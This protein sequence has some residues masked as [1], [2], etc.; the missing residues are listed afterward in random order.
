MGTANGV[1]CRRNIRQSQ[2]QSDLRNPPIQIAH[3]TEQWVALSRNQLNR[4]S[5]V[6]SQMHARLAT[7]RSPLMYSLANGKRST[8]ALL[9]RTTSFNSAVAILKLISDKISVTSY[10]LN[11]YEIFLQRK[12]SVFFAAIKI[13]R[14]LYYQNYA[15]VGVTHTAATALAS[16]TRP[17]LSSPG[18]NSRSG[19]GTFRIV[20]CVT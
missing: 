17:Q 16:S 9:G 15:M 14:F 13:S 4:M 5:C 2:T 12:R 10:H 3:C 20:S 1:E 6:A 7:F 18:F 8:S 19:G 11:K